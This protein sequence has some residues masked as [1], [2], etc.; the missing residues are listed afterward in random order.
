VVRRVGVRGR[1]GFG[2]AVA[3]GIPQAV[4]L[5]QAL[6]HGL[7][8]GRPSAADVGQAGKVV[9]GKVRTAQ[10]VDDHGGNV[11][12]GGD[13]V[14]RYEAARQVAVPPGHDD[15][16]GAAVDGRMH[17]AHHA[18][19]VEHGHHRQRHVVGRSI[20]PQAAGHCV[21]HDAFVQV[22]AALGQPRGTAGVGQQRQV[23]R[24]HGQ[25]GR[26]VCTGQSVR[27]RVGLPAIQ[28]RQRVARAQPVHP[29]RG[30]RIDAGHSHVEGIRKLCHHQVRQ[31]LARGQCI[32]GLGHLGGQVTGGDG[33]LGIGVGDV[34]LEL[35]GPVHGVDRHH[36][37]VGPQDGEVR[38]HQLR[39]VLH[40]Q[41]HAVAALHPQL[42][43]PG[44]QALRALHQLPIA[45]CR[46][47]K[48]QRRLVRVAA[49]VGGQVV[50]QRGG[51]QRDGMGKA[52]GPEL[53]VRAHG[54]S[55]PL[56]RSLEAPHDHGIGD[57]TDTGSRR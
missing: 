30:R 54:Y 26:C 24:P 6:R 42:R 22:H 41:H 18:G 49:R 57:A 13:L 15:Q 33:D 17:H 45:R 21:V 52:A 16:G 7:G 46:P 28:C 32:A 37:G 43:Q 36:H 11:G 35:L 38:H 44:R 2:Q 51:G 20:A 9:A 53:V 29:R 48:N 27:P 1:S 39:A 14:A 56:F 19:D 4:L 5:Q 12:P 31:A 50:P 25:G 34:V 47:K 3:F 23:G 10:Q 8:H 55:V 40:A